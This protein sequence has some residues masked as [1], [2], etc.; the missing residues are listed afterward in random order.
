MQTAFGG[1]NRITTTLYHFFPPDLGEDGQTLAQ[2][3]YVEVSKLLSN[4][5]SRNFN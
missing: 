1:P 4:A 5:C 3:F 2:D